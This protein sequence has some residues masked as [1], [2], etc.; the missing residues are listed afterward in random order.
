MGK[1][2]K[3]LFRE[4]KLQPFLDVNGI[5][6]KKKSF[7]LFTLKL[8]EGEVVPSS[9]VHLTV[10]SVE[11]FGE[12]EE[13]RPEFLYHKKKTSDDSSRRFG[14]KTEKGAR[15]EGK[16]KKRKGRFAQVN[17]KAKGKVFYT[18]TCC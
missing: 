8:G 7:P 2:K 16:K 18:I 5:V 9:F 17:A 15:K 3:F 13:K 1:K 12:S 4:K 14:K 11:T 10:Q 6:K